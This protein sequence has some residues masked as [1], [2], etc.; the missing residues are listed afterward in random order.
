MPIIGP[1]FRVTFKLNVYPAVWKN[2][3][4]LVLRKPAR[5]SYSKPSSFRPIALLDTIGKILSA[6]V[7]EDL[8]NFAETHNLLPPNHFGCR[9]G[10]TTTDAIHY[11]AAQIKDA[12]RK[13]EVV[14][15]LFLDIKGA[16]PSVKLNR[17][18]HNMRKRGIPKQYTDWIRSK[19][20]YRSTQLV[21]DDYISPQETLHCGIDQGCPLSGI[22]FLF[23]NADLL[24]ITCS[25]NG[26]GSVA[27]VDD[28]T[29]LA[30]GA[31]LKETTKK[32][33]EIMNRQ[34]GLL[35][36]SRSHGCEFALNK[37]ALIGFTRRRT[38]DETRKGKT[39]PILRPS[40]EIDGH[41]I[42]SS[43]THKFL[44]VHIDQELRFKEQTAEALRKGTK[45]IE[46]YKHLAKTM[47]GVS[48]KHM[49]K[50]YYT[51]ALPKMLYAADVFLIPES[52]TTKGTVGF[53]RNL[54]RI[55]RQA[56]IAITGAL[57]TTATNIMEMH[58]HVPTFKALLKDKLHREATRFACLPKTHPLYK[59]VC[60][61][62][63]RYVKRHRAPIH[64]LLHAFDLNPLQMEK[65]APVSRGPKWA[66][67]HR[68]RIHH[69][70]SKAIEELDNCFGTR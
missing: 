20:M 11:V 37:F 57:K 39:K 65:I 70:K 43:T 14:S 49:M 33:V 55:H 34:N 35:T 63:R 54:A 7:A 38:P 68:T 41:V 50:F 31:D 36:W 23:Y 3:I 8:S 21:F 2:S 47:K 25:A 64:E 60:K 9:P 44:G 40:I 52:N 4:T 62:A 26:E 42:E 24:E 59:T 28:A 19:V 12:W 17:L 69:D 29:I 13:G 51:I 5:A 1:I 56:L 66:P 45:W 30:K 61:A 18:I 32:L 58:A 6:C 48:A 53:I 16:F 67:R 10:R 27:V 15:A 22:L 46:Q